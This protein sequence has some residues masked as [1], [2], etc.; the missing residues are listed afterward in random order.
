MR[1][2][3]IPA[4]LALALG[5]M[6]LAATSVHAAPPVIL[7]TS[8]TPTSTTSVVLKA[9]INPGGKATS[10]HFE[11]GTSECPASCTKMPVPDGS[12]PIGGSQVS[13]SVD[14][15]GLS[16]ATTYHFRVAAKNPE[17]G[18]Y[19][20][21]PD[22]PFATFLASI[23]GLPDARAYEQ[24]SPVDKNAGDALATF[25]YAK[26]ASNGGGAIF[27]ST[28][29]IPG[30]VGA[31]TIPP[32]LGS[33]GAGDWS[34]QGLLAPENMG[35][36]S[37]VIG[38]LP[39]FS[40]FFVTATQF[41]NPRSTALLAR[42]SAGGPPREIAPY[43]NK[44]AYS[45]AG[46]TED[47]GEIVFE[48]KTALGTTPAGIEGR[49]N[50]YA[51]DRASGQLSLAGVLN[52]KAETEAALPKGAFAGPYDWV[53]GST[54]GT[55]NRGGAARDYYIQ[56]EHAITADGSIYFTAAGT[57][58]LYLRRNP[59]KA[60]S[61][62]D[63]GECADPALACTIKVSAS[64]KTNGL[65]PGGRDAAGP[66]PAV[67]MTATPD[68]SAAFF[69][70]PEKLTNDAN[71]GPE[72]PPP[73]PP[74]IDRA[75]LGGTIEDEKLIPAANGSGI[76]V[77]G[78][79]IYWADPKAGAI[80]RANLDGSE[81]KD[82]FITDVNPVAVAVDAEYVYWADP[83]GT[84][85]RAKLTDGAEVKEDFISGAGDPQG[86]AVDGGHVYWTN[87]SGHSIGR[88]GIDGGGADP[89]FRTFC[90]CAFP[91]A[92][93]VDGTHIVFSL[94][95]PS[96]EYIGETNLEGG[97]AD[98]IPIQGEVAGVALDANHIYWSE[99]DKDTIGRAGLHREEP[100]EEAFIEDVP[101]PQGVAVD[102]AHI[103]WSSVPF[104][105]D[106][107]GNDLY[108]FEAGK[109]AGQ[110]LVD[111][112]PDPDGN[113]ADVKGVLGAS[114]DGSVVYFAANGVL[115][116]SGAVEPGDC[117]GKSFDSLSGACNLYLWHDRQV[118]F[119]A[120]LDI[121]GGGLQMDATN[122]TG[123]PSGVFLGEPY[124][125]KTASVS[126]DGRTLLFRSQE[127]LT[128]YDS[129]GH[130]ELYRYR[131][132]DPEPLRCVT[133]DPTG[134][135]P[136][137]GGS[138]LGGLIAPSAAK[139][140][141]PASVA[142]RNLSADANR[143]FFETTQAL[144]SAD[145]NGVAGCPAVGSQAQG[146]PACLDVYEWEAPGKGSCKEGAPSFSPPN[147]GCLYLLSSGK[148][149]Y[150]SFFADASASGEDAFI[151]TREGLVGQDKD[152]LLDLYDAK[153]GGGLP[154]QNPPPPAPCE[155][156]DACQGPP[157]TPPASES[158][159]S[160]SFV[161]PGD[162]KPKRQHKKKARKHT[163]K[164]QKKKSGARKRS[165]VAPRV[166]AGGGEEPQGRTSS[167]D[168]D[169]AGAAGAIAAAAGG[170]AAPAWKLTATPMP[171][172][173]AP[174]ANSEYQLAATNVGAAS[175][176]GDPTVFKATLPSGLTPIAASVDSDD[177]S[178]G[179]EF[180]CEIEAPIVTCTTTEAVH[181]GRVLSVLLSVEVSP[182]SAGETLSAET[183]VEGGG[184]NLKATA[185]VSTP[186]SADPVPFE[187]SPDFSAPLNDEDGLPATAA[188]THPYQL[189]VD[190][191]FPVENPGDGFTGSGH[192]RDIVADLPRGL[193]GDPAATPVLC[194]EAELTSDEKC[195]EGSQVGLID[196]MTLLGQKGGIIVAS[197][198]Y[199][200]VPPPGAPAVFG[201]NAA[202]VGF[203]LH[204]KGEVR[205]ES[206]YGISS[207]SHDALALGGTPIFKVQAQI[208]GDP[209]SDA[210]SEVRGVCQIA[211]FKPDGKGGGE[212]CTV[213]HQDTAFLT[214]PG[215]CPGKPT[216][217]KG[218]ADSWEEPGVG[219]E[220]SY[221]SA[222]LAGTPRSTEDCGGLA[223]EPK[224]KAR[225]TTNLT[226]SPS[227]IDITLHQPQDFNLKDR[228][229]AAL[230]DATITFPAGMAVNPS[231]ASG[232]GACSLDQ[233][234]FKQEAGVH[235][236]KTP[237]SCPEAAK[238]G[239]IEVSSP[240]LVQ[241]NP[242]HEVEKDP[243]TG[244]PIPEPL[245]G[246]IYLAKPFQNPFDSLVA[247]Y[248]V[249]EDEK[250]GIVAKLAGKGE[251]DPVTGQ[252]TT[253]F[254]ENPELPLEDFKAHLFGG[255]RGA[256][257]TPPTCT[258][259]TSTAELTPWSAPE[260]PSVHLTDSFAPTAP[261][262]AGP[263]P[264]TEAQ[265]PNK[266]VLT[267]GTVSPQ[268]GKYSPLVF[269]L[270]RQDGSQR[271]AKIDTTLPPGLS[272]RLAGTAS[273]PEA[274]IA[275]AKARE[276]PNQGA[277]EQAD[278]SC[279]A[280]SEVG[281][282]TVGAGAGPTP[283]Y[284]QAHAYLAGPYKGAPLSLAIIA[285]AV[286]GPF[287]LGTVVSRA[288][289]FLDPTTAQGR[290]VSDP[291]PTIIDGI[292][293]DLRSIA[294]KV[295]R[296]N[297]TLNPTSCAEKAFAGS[298]TSTL[299]SAA[300]LSERFQVGGCKSLPYKP[301]LTTRLFGPIHRGGHPRFRVVFTAKPGEANTKRIVLALPK[302]EFID[303]S[304]FRTI[305][306]RVQYAANQCPAGAV[307]GHVKAISPL[308]DYPLQGPIYLRSSSHQLPDAVAALRGP[309]SQPI[310]IDGVGRVDSVNGGLRTTV[311]TVPDA[312]L[313]KLI[314]T[315]QG[316]KKGLFQNSTN[317]CKGT[318]RAT[319][320]LTGQNGKTYDTKPLMKADCPKP[321]KQ[322]RGGK[323]R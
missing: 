114:E 174:G 81:V 145:T 17:S 118:S 20:F 260:A 227:G 55:L 272:A 253:R 271:L 93:A 140:P 290:V 214:T 94:E 98:F 68:G 198:L 203:F 323:R 153:V 64:Q 286:A 49:S 178:F 252:I 177:R 224:I 135:S 300:A 109:P 41:G 137:A 176:N 234:G 86:V 166:S 200:M 122:W 14:V 35:Q 159:G 277:A 96:G 61:P 231:Q 250:T 99:A 106:N 207:A 37:G 117:A 303:Q 58:Q 316:A 60:Q 42:P 108:R 161:G 312:P 59:T 251:L 100:R 275:K 101:S 265:M 83:E 3:A 33:R 219:H 317:I 264:T 126:A 246:S 10:Y 237:Q 233:I 291:L 297:F 65:G 308:L 71:T 289:I 30:G 162:P 173:F 319:V 154:S 66:R 139:P 80:E 88:T 119:I 155:S 104:S 263:C 95:E 128:A 158:A 124:F 208:W 138:F 51:W 87:Q 24:V 254:E 21:S 7:G 22:K 258:T 156:S 266:P 152:E 142:S 16:E 187:L 243:E 151:F 192:P 229:T 25:S 241:R 132:G 223:F 144:V 82:D 164:G 184:A 188:G 19:L 238:L 12:I 215:D 163:K 230:K 116:G 167:S 115:G 270:T 23:E 204:I 193:I 5:L 136:I 179:S 170:A 148:D 191:S 201:T 285:P 216:L 171:A 134:S 182:G 199:A 320:S 269:K 294:M 232:L 62:L 295:S 160:A 90:T 105:A 245:H 54:Q 305:C 125:S 1:R 222:D 240:L 268:A 149:T 313:T 31:Q 150:P 281:V 197:N 72:F 121:G 288:A 111:L 228:S 310:A 110:R 63:E 120:R 129:E 15:T 315:L 202:G 307:Y 190:L 261:P 279:P 40:E 185:M 183:S 18:G 220:A 259:Q 38:W 13:V 8:F 45:F 47:G 29:G 282:V 84:I 28:S 57:G 302:S 76:A 194:T 27:L 70:S 97:P 113:G 69:T 314:V 299:G 244:E 273:C 236:D 213:P 195:P 306:T 48:S 39:D 217:F 92:I 44:A 226:D 77:D 50:V 91:R 296:P 205:S 292:P 293:L 276:Q 53:L 248:L 249:V 309:P 147:G 127:K 189:T 169:A 206:D 133:C 257:V 172:N 32:Y 4:T 298:L 318:H 287:D 180:K 75:S 52:S 242:D 79:H 322:K 26:A 256:F 103:Y 321:Q 274:Q 218:L 43:A 36:L 73:L 146:F 102:G 235:F 181:P 210:H 78:A 56:G 304:H 74:S 186:I 280:S 46:A 211:G 67:F 267:A 112:T 123:T 221:E 85:G 262:T 107:P 225:P 168:G 141:L 143:V 11:Y 131:V 311:E 196:L 209:S 255:A 301:K 6:A 278:P 2:H 247:V 284:T 175:S 34:T 212:P 157:S 283:Y 9:E 89:L 165:V 239:T 130:P